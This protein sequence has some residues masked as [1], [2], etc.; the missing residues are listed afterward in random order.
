VIHVP[1]TEGY[2]E[3]L[4]PNQPSVLIV[5]DKPANLLALSAVL[6]PLGIRIV[7]ARSGREALS[8]FANES[9]AV[10]LLDA[11]MP[12]MDGFEV[13]QRIRVSE[14]DPDV[15]IIFLTA[16]YRD[17]SYARRGYASGAADYI[18]KPIDPT[19]LRARVGAFVDLYRQREAV[20]RVEV[21]RRT[22]ER[23]EAVR[24][25]VAFERIATAALEG[26]D[27]DAFLHEL[28]DTF[29]QATSAVDSAAILLR[30]ASADGPDEL[31]LRAAVGKLAMRELSHTSERVG[32]GFAGRIAATLKPMEID[33]ASNSNI[34]VS[35]LLQGTDVSTI[36]GV[37]LTSGGDAL[38]V[39]FVASSSKNAL[40]ERDKRLFRT[41]AERASW[42]VGKYE[43]H[44]RLRDVLDFSPALIATTRGPDHVCEFANRAFRDF[45]S[46]APGCGVRIASLGVSEVAIEALDR[47]YRTGE[48]TSTREV[49]LVVDWRPELP[50]ETRY[51][52]LYVQRLQTP[53]VSRDD[54]LVFAIDVSAKVHARQ[55]IERHQIERT[56][57]LESERTARTEA[58]MANRAKD[59]FLATVSHELRT[60]LNAVIGWTTLARASATPEVDHA[61]AVIERNA[62]AQARIIEDMLDI[63]R[64]ISGQLRLEPRTIRVSDIVTAALESTRPAAE[65]KGVVLEADIDDCGTIV[66]DPDRLQQ[67][68]WNLLSNAIKFTPRAG[69]V[70]L[71]SYRV[72]DRLKIE[73]VDTG[74]GIEP[75]FLPQVFEAFRQEDG[76]T[77]RRHGGLGLGLAI[78]KQLVA[79]HG[80][81]IRAQSEGQGRGSTFTVDLPATA[82]QAPADQVREVEVGAGGTEDLR[83]DGLDVLVVDDETDARTLFAKVLCARGAKVR[84]AAS[85]DEALAMIDAGVPDVLVSD[86]AM[87]DG[88]GYMLIRAVRRRP[89]SRG[90]KTPAIAVTAYARRE[91]I[92]RAFAAGFQ[93]H[94]EK[95]VEL[96]RLVS[97]VANLGGRTFD[98]S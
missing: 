84:T 11:Q 21:A 93:Q 98:G 38:G 30:S 10:I 72:G 46:K 90:G 56:R 68:V 52:D 65:A 4:V 48:P 92:E 88:D 69:R 25:L 47:T 16:A 77:T 18:T 62:R 42:A 40:T 44:T 95:P 76:S 97:L 28:L 78:V 12:E 20:R 26:A 23:D 75:E 58:E 82:P 15:P 35:P 49:P 19:I 3:A 79:A 41:L 32:E 57:L 71:H 80:G 8:R 64:V 91:D 14:R 94:V 37:P 61:L 89:A 67:V 5:D 6:K 29:A 50:Q 55:E 34:V 43:E 70:S 74:R 13:A 31:H 1:T 9:F 86:I 81:T 24:R 59:E 33:D 2:D 83:V 17:E 51:F 87:P 54:L 60:P 66:A 73:V 36:F 53:L 27:L 39:A 85:M 45:F 22:E 63:S 7:E 96:G